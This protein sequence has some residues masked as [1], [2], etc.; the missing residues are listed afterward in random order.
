M[1]LQS[2]VARPRNPYQAQGQAVS[3]ARY[4]LSL[5]GKLTLSFFGRLYSL[6]TAIEEEVIHDFETAGKD[7]GRGKK[8][9]TYQRSRDE[10]GN[11][12][13]GRTGNRG[14]PC[15]CRPLVR[16]HDSH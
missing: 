1:A 6:E 16:V 5:R 3:L 11:G 2:S 7:E 4:R 8:G 14:D 13:G 10:R 12:A 15:G 9:H